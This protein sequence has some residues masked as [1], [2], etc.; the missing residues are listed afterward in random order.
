MHIPKDTIIDQRFRILGQ[1][2]SG[3]MGDVYE[4]EQ[5][6]LGRV[7][8][9]KFLNE[10]DLCDAESLARFQREA[11]VISQ[12]R[13]KNIVAIYAFGVWRKLPYMVIERIN[14][15]SLDSL[16]QAR[17]PLDPAFVLDVGMQVCAGLQVAHDAGVVHRDIKPHNLLLA[18]TR[19]VK[20]IDFGL[21]KVL[22][23]LSEEQQLTEAGTTL[24]TVLYM[25]PEQV[26]C[27]P[28]DARADVYALACVL[29]HCLTGGP[30]FMSDSAISVMRMQVNDPPPRIDHIEAPV[31]VKASL[32]A[33]LGKGMAKDP[34]KRYQS[35]KDMLKDLQ[36]VHEGCVVEAPPVVQ[37]RAR[38]EAA[39]SKRKA[40]LT[41]AA[42]LVP[43]ALAGTAATLR[44]MPPPASS[45]KPG[46]LDS[47]EEGRNLQ[48]RIDALR[49]R[50]LES[51]PKA[52]Y[53]AA[54]AELAPLYDKLAH[55]DERNRVNNAMFA[56]HFAKGAIQ[57]APFTTKFQYLK[58][59]RGCLGFEG[60]RNSF[61]EA[62]HYLTGE[63]DAAWN[64]NKLRPARDGY[65]AL[66]SMISDVGSEPYWV[67][68]QRYVMCRLLES[69]G[70]LNNR[71]DWLADAEQCVALAANFPSNKQS[72]VND[73]F[74]RLK[75][76]GLHD[77]AADLRQR[78]DAHATSR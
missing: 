70:K 39:G 73:I 27:Q 75:G 25:S 32:Q 64:A 21:A 57:A 63:C 62:T 17:E 68:Q 13:H 76:L 49:S 67:D 48:R 72:Y 45:S 2:G 34:A 55:I 40:I 65:A 15:T 69:D 8:A 47:I 53:S 12:L 36:A 43:L 9:I 44:F 78:F 52:E 5:T 51:L 54:C 11:Q 46:Q 66:L 31:E 50:T 19:D 28:V 24:G 29:H 60:Q 6:D 33:V 1:I 14:G 26:L 35:A 4:A 37:D 7:V 59:L 71:E 61:Y 41:A 10:K 58:K 74:L 16:L 22:A 23:P 3:G 20:I 42:V 77:S 38:A 18:D 30:P 56:I